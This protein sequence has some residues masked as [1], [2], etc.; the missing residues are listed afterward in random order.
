MTE[1][2]NEKRR[3]RKRNEEEGDREVSHYEKWNA[4]SRTT[5]RV[6]D[7]RKRSKVNFLIYAT[8]HRRRS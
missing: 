6:K 3:K 4:L 2:K 5:D 8:H 1:E 7:K